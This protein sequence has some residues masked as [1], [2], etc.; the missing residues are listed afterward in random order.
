M[1][2]LLLLLL[3]IF[4]SLFQLFNVWIIVLF[5]SR[6]PLSEYHLFDCRYTP[7]DGSGP[8]YQCAD[9]RIERPELVGTTTLGIIITNTGES[10]VPSFLSFVFF[11]LYKLVL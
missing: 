2:T 3:E 10:L 4:Q 7:N 5:E 9:V 1:K 6:T 11:L 8:F